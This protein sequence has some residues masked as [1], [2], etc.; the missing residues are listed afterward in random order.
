MQDWDRIDAGKFA[1]EGEVVAALLASAPLDPAARQSVSARA[2]RLVEGARA[3][4]QKQGVVE[5]FL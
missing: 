3:S 5:S 1:D 2:A 4:A